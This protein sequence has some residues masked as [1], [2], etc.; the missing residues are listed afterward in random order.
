MNQT[1]T[2]FII[3]G[4]SALHG[5]V[6]VAGAKNAA[7]KLMIAALLGSNE[8]KILNLPAISDVEMV[9]EVIESLGGIAKA[10]GEGTRI[11]DPRSLNSFQ[12]GEQYGAVSRAST[13]F[14][15]ALL[16]RFGEARVPLP[17]GDQIGERPLERHFAGLEKM[18]AVFSREEGMLVVQAD[19]LRGTH[20]KFTKNTHTGTETLLMAAVLAEGKTV[21]ENAALEPEVDDLIVLL[22]EMGADIKRTTHR[23]IEINGVA[24]L[25]GAT[26]KVMPDRN[27]AISYACAALAT[28]GDIVVENA[29]EQDLRAF[30]DKL[31]EA[32]AGYE[33]KDYGIR[34]F[35]KGPLQATELTTEIHP[36]FM[37]DWQPLWAILM[38]HAEGVSTIHEAVMQNRFQYVEVLQQMGAKIESWQPEVNNPEQFYNFNWQ[39]AK[40]ED[41]RAIKI[42]GPTNFTG[43]EFTVHDLRAGATTLIAAIS[44]TGQTTLHN[45]EQIERGYSAID[46]KL[47]S[48]GANIQRLGSD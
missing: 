16:V 6:K 31:D 3:Q 36:G 21:L 24:Q 11:I 5:S 9:A 19:G 35:Y 39:D 29:R 22:N 15:P 17:G 18:G 28:K 47:V 14:I 12:I 42:T 32:Q 10:A 26:H 13:L 25:G 46:E 23:T 4:G 41:V 27:E 7:Y 45:V 44:G 8:S 38:C 33:I 43:G 40:A 37:T 48:M 1:H 34:F 20:Y 2:S 30:L